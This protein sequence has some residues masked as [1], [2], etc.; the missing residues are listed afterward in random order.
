MVSYITGDTADEFDKLVT[1]VERWIVDHPEEG[2]DEVLAIWIAPQ[3][4]LYTKYM[5][6]IRC[7]ITR[8]HTHINEHL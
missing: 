8:T 6:S 1:I 4:K 7:N 2:K 5:V 3:T